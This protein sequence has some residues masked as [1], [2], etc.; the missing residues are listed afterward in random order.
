MVKVV[1]QAY[2]YAIIS[3][4]MS[5]GYYKNGNYASIIKGIIGGFSSTS[6]NGNNRRSN[7][8]NLVKLATIR[9]NFQ[10]GQRH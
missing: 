9:M 4:D 7:W 10:L 2:A 5:T 1:T 3:G 8:H 6:M